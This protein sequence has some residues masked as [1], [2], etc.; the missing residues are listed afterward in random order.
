M[1]NSA[2]LKLAGVFTAVLMCVCL[3][4]ACG[5]KSADSYYSNGTEYKSTADYDAEDS[6]QTFSEENSV[7]SEQRKLIR[8]VSL[9]LETKDFSEFTDAFEKEVGL[10]GGYIESQSENANRTRGYRSGN[11]V[12]RI[13]ADK[14]DDFLSAVSD[15]STVLYKSSETEDVTDAYIDVESR[16]AA[17]E[18]EYDSLLALLE[19]ADSLSDIIKIQDRLSEVRGDLESYKARIKSYDSK[20]QY[21]SVTVSVREVEY[22]SAD[23]KGFWEETGDKI[24]ENFGIVADGLR[25]FAIFIIGSVPFLA[26]IA[27]VLAIVL[28]IVK[29]V[30]GKKRRRRNKSKANGTGKANYPERQNEDNGSENAGDSRQ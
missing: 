24:A 13:P 15:I 14:L 19:K 7:V 22:T 10:T 6:A 9:T 20:I 30:S 16:I 23:D 21:S 28:I 17:L 18:T 12:V 1:K 8:N 26:V 5:A 29:A 4:A 2:L 11:Y 25:S 27:V 3:F